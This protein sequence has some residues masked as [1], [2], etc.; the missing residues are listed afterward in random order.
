M[1]PVRICAAAGEMVTTTGARMVT[2]ADADLV[3]SASD[4]A[5]TLTCA[6]LGAVLGAV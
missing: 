2:V 3:E 1:R 5:V 6:G 4:V